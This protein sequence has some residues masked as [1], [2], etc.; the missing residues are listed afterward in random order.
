MA[1]G[2]RTLVAI[3]APTWPPSLCQPQ[4]SLQTSPGIVRHP[5]SLLLPLSFLSLSCCPSLRFFLSFLPPSYPTFLSLPTFPFL[6][7]ALFIFLASVSPALLP[8]SPLSTVLPFL[9]SSPVYLPPLSLFLA[10]Y[11]RGSVSFHCTASLTPSFLWEA[12]RDLHH[13]P[14]SLLPHP[15]GPP[16]PN[17]G[18]LELGS[19]Q[20]GHSFYFLF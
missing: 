3:L 10:L 15:S 19:G 6:P 12:P 13:R 18:S 9:W 11:S 4:A 7:F 20:R 14:S 1:L 16:R 8:P 2:C 17:G 5:P